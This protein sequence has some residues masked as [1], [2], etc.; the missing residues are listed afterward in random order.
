L[1]TVTG[2][3]PATAV[4]A[5]LNLYVDGTS[6]VGEVYHADCLSFH[7]GAGGQWAMPGTP[8]TGTG[9]RVR[10]GG[11][12]D[13]WDGTQWLNIGTGTPVTHAEQ[14]PAPDTVPSG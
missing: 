9:Y 7:K 8:I 1:V 5:S 3:A 14:L 12:V 4:Y 2:V 10:P 6:G 11:L 13:V